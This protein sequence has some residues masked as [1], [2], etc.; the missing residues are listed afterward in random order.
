MKDLSQPLADANAYEAMRQAEKAELATRLV[1]FKA[2]LQGLPEGA[3]PLDRASLQLEIARTMAHLE[4][5]SDG[6]S[7]AKEAFSV[8]HESE[9]WERAVD[10]LDVLFQCNQDESLAALGQGLW[11]AVTFPVDPELT[12][13]LLD[14]VV[15]ETPDDSDGGAVAA[16]TAVYIADLRDP[17]G[18]EG[19]LGFFARQM[20]GNVARRHSDVETQDQF[21]A[22]VMRMELDD[23]SKFL[24]RLRNVIDVLVQENWWIDRD[25]I[26]A[27]LPEE[28]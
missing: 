13:A 28:G 19:N 15:D 22:W 8:F 1:D 9:D 26:T 17:D 7:M 27:S 4:E 18:P 2:K 10:A 6:W 11:L 14:H 21:D 3:H 25:A 16:A 23:P 5:G 20:L 12:I 24:V